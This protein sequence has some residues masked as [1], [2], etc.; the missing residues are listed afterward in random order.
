M[1]RIPAKLG[2]P[3]GQYLKQRLTAHSPNRSGVVVEDE[4][5]RRLVGVCVIAPFF[6]L[7]DGQSFRVNDLIVD[8]CYRGKGLGSA[9]LRG[10]VE[11]AQSEDI[12]LVEIAAAHWNEPV[13][14]M[15]E[16]LGFEKDPVLPYCSYDVIVNRL[17]SRRI[18]PNISIDPPF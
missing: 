11:I 10:C 6:S 18:N 16:R 12:Q 3:R 14:K 17:R 9:L 7:S 15:Y 13:V 8:S 4:S 1:A 2:P 5:V